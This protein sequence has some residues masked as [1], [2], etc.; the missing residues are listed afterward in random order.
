LKTDLGLHAHRYVIYIYIYY[1]T[2]GFTQ[3][4]G[5]R[6]RER[7]REGERGREIDR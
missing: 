7:E 4:E 3:R 1:I 2:G 6:G 5:E